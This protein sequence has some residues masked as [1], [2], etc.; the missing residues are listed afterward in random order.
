VDLRGRRLGGYDIEALLGEGGMGRVYRARDTRLGRHVALKLVPPELAVDPERRR[1]FEREARTLAAL[2]H[3]HIAAIYGLEEAVFDGVPVQALVLEL[4]DGATLA[5]RLART[6]KMPLAA[7]L[8][9]ARQIAEALE[10][11]HEKGIV[12]RD[13]KPANVALT[14]EG[15]VKVLDFGLAKGTVVGTDAPSAH[16]E[17]GAILGT[18]AYMSP[19]QA[20]GQAVDARTDIWAFGC[21]LFE[22]LT[23]RSPFGGA[24]L[25]DTL[26]AVLDRQ[27][28][29]TALPGD[30]PPAIHRLIQRCLEKEPRRRVHAAAD[31]RIALEDATVADEIVPQMRRSAA[32]ALWLV[33]SAA[34]AIAAAI[35]WSAVR[36]SSPDVAPLRLD[37][38][39]PPTRDPDSFALSL[40]GRHVAFVAL[41]EQIPYLWLRRLDGTVP[42]R[43]P[44]TEGASQPFWAPSGRSIG[45]L[46]DGLLKRVDVTGGRP[47]VLAQAR[48][49]MGG[50]WNRDDVIVYSPYAASPLMRVPATGGTPE[51]VTRLSAGELGHR[52]PAFL[53]DGRRLL[54]LAVTIAPQDEGVHLV[55]LDAPTRR[56]RVVAS[57]SGA[58]FVR[59]GHVL[60]MRQGVLL[61]FPF[62][63]EAGVV[64]GDPVVVAPRVD[65]RRSGRG[66]FSASGSGL[67]AYRAA[68]TASFAQ[69]LTWLDRGGNA[70][71][72]L[73]KQGYPP[74]TPDGQLAAVVEETRTL[75]LSNADIWL[76]HVARGVAQRF[77]SDPAFDLLAVWSPDGNRLAFASNRNGVFDL[78]EKAVSFSHDERALL[79]TPENKYPDGQTLLFVNEHAV[80][81]D[82]LW[83]LS[84]QVPRKAVPLLSGNYAESQGQF[85][86]DGRWIAYRSNESGRWEI[87]VRPFPGPGSP[88][89]ISQ[90]GGRQPRWRRDGRELFYIGADSQMTAVPIHLQPNGDAF[91]LGG[92]TPLFTTQ[93]AVPNNQQFG[94]AVDAQGQRF[95][96][97]M[98]PD[99][100]STTPVTIVQ[101]WIAGSAK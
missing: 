13:L 62:D 55:S 43:F 91:E 89:L 97:F 22:M 49:P 31:V 85:S 39:T 63:T 44:K 74:L 4:V 3:P 77:T 26:A 8:D 5:D 20:R 41:N 42:Q 7:A 70:I 37:V 1:R 21:V 79:E 60:T 2:N 38:V 36:S 82:D 69:E 15:L 92:P 67:V 11:A 95:L 100:T 66:A 64:S 19:E 50:A 40:D 57:D 65:H 52:Y 73:T 93:L 14:S 59:P 33:A 71:A 18:A 35:G 9:L 96:V 24:T 61:A 78:F 10:A 12:H 86:P 76:I 32:P 51:A 48:N 90:G 34:I 45:F 87:Y 98:V 17:S 25:S 28:D 6:G 75:A 72:K 58:Q 29:W 56:H 16:T 30:L 54:F 23:G 68:G 83:T 46:A 80:T 27:P 88:R 81:G 53:P 94:Y 101:N 47:Q 99:Q 84:L